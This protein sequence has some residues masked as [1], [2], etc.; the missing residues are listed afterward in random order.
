MVFAMGLKFITQLVF[1]S[2]D[3]Q[4]RGIIRN[5]NVCNIVQ[6]CKVRNLVSV[7]IRGVTD[8]L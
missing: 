8:L 6:V 1:V 4:S 5:I 2:L 3:I 7:T